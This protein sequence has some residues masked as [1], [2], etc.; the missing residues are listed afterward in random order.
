MEVGHVRTAWISLNYL[1]NVRSPS[2]PRTPLMTYQNGIRVP[3]CG[4]K[5]LTSDSDMLLL[6]L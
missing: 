6:S 3:M 1:E 4:L 2:L 5:K